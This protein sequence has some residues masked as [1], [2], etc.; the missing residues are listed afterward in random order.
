VQVE[1]ITPVYGSLAVKV[2]RFRPGGPVRAASVTV[3]GQPVPATMGE[4]EGEVVLTL[5]RSWL[6]LAGQTLA[7]TLSH[8]DLL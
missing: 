6:L 5:E 4:A 3:D 2:L 1:T 7:V 8:H